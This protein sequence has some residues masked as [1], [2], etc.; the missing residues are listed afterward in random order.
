[1]AEPVKN[2]LF[3]CTGNSAR[4]ILA[5]AI[6]DHWGKGLF[7][8][9]SAGSFPKGKV[10]PLALELLAQFGMPTTHLRSKSWDEFAKS[11]APVMDYIFT[12]CDDA[13]GEVCP[14]W[15]G[16]PVTAHWGL[17]DPAAVKGSPAVQAAAFR[18]AF[19]VLEARI[20]F[21]LT[22][23]FKTWDRTYLQRMVLEAG[24]RQPE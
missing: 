14:V 2:V 17:P 9:Y 7:K 24:T 12:V 16:H 4:S 18:E 20:R 19:R 15:P 3:L 22:F 5:E 21:F 8:G 10:H 11:D 1:M 13:A 6:L 23:Q